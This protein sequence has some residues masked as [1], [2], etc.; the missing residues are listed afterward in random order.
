MAD[1]GHS[2]TPLRRLWRRRWVR[3]TALV[4]GVVLIAGTALAG[5]LVLRYRSIGRERFGEGTLVEGSRGKPQNFLVVGTDSRRFVDDPSEAA[6]FGTVEESGAPHADTILVVRTLPELNRVAM[7]SFPRD[8]FVNVAGTGGENR[9]NTALEG[10]PDRLVQTISENFG[11]PVNH[12]LEVDFR[13]FKTL[14]DA[15]GGVTVYFPAPVRDW[16]EQKRVNPTGL[17][18]RQTGCVELGGEQALAYVRSRHYQQLID[19]EWQSDPAGDLNR[20]TRQQEFIR[21][22]LAQAVARG[23]RNPARLSSLI[24][25]AV[26][27]VT[28]DSQLRFRDLTTLSRQFRSVQPESLQSY[29]LPTTPGKTAAGADVLFL[30]KA[31][32]EPILDV[33]R[34]K[35]TAPPILLPSAVRVR[36]VHSPSQSDAGQAAGFR[37]AA[38]G[39][40]VD[41]TAAAKAGNQRTV[42][43]H[44]EGGREKAEVLASR[45]IGPVELQSSDAVDGADVVLMIGRDW[46]GI[47]PASDDVTAAPTTTAPEP[48]DPSA[49]DAAAATSTTTPA[50]SPTPTC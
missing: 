31:A 50:A 36:V 44:P 46:R 4:T 2:A 28:L 38:A 39:F 40:V 8:L 26:Q 21:K 6:S 35:T 14:V 13:G 29:A 18:I 41:T 25:V 49:R 30:D 32:S 9:I 37:L 22:T 48:D 19:G 47:V 7:V 27:N 23:F 24:D 5:S 43:Q 12:F 16:D 34:G 11:I 20:I 17:D 1:G 10:G 33:F 42:I 3:V 45:V 15:I